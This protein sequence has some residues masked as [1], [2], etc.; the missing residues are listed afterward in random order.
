MSGTGAI[1]VGAEFLQQH[2]KCSVAFISDPTW[3]NH[4]A[5]FKSAGFME[6]KKYQYWNEENKNLNFKGMV[7]DLKSAPERAVVV[8]H[9][10]AHNP[11]GSFFNHH[12]LKILSHVTIKINIHLLYIFMI[13]LGVDP[14]KLQWKEIADIIEEKKLI[15]FFDCAYQGIF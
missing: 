6:I 11:T 10:C 3:P 15:P 13:F 8:L 9:G 7:E 14:T 5:I 1:R 4:F 2:L 12:I